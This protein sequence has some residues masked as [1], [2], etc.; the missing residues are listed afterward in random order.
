MLTTMMVARAC[1]SRWIIN[2]YIHHRPSD[3]FLLCARLGIQEVAILN[4]IRLPVY[5]VIHPVDVHKVDE[6]DPWGIFR[7]LLI[8]LPRG[9]DPPGMTSRRTREFIHDPLPRLRDRASVMPIGDFRRVVRGGSWL[10]DLVL[11]RA[12]SRDNYA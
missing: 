2:W 6:E 3:A 4:G 9:L 10:G 7:P 11:A 1:S 12:S 8:K 5:P